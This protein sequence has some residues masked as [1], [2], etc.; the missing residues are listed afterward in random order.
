MSKSQFLII[1]AIA[2]AFF[3]IY[4]K[5][6][7]VENED[8]EFQNLAIEKEKFLKSRIRQLEKEI[9]KLMLDKEKLFHLIEKTIDNQPVISHEEVHQITWSNNTINSSPIDSSLVGSS[10]TRRRSLSEISSLNRDNEKERELVLENQE[11]TLKLKSVRTILRH[12]L[13]TDFDEGKHR[14]IS[15]CDKKSLYGVFMKNV[16]RKIDLFGNHIAEFTTY[17]LLL[18]LTPRLSDWT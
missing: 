1:S 15:S 14:V 16:S 18:T 7:E 13:L 3:Y 10:E 8:R 11:L 12:H 4:K 6:L 9:E 2:T 5:I 17:S